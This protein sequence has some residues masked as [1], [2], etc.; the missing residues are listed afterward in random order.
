MKKRMLDSN[1]RRSHSHS[2]GEDKEDCPWQGTCLSLGIEQLWCS[3]LHEQQG[4]WVSS[5]EASGPETGG[6][7]GISLES[8]R[9]LALPR[10]C[11]MLVI[12]K[13]WSEGAWGWRRGGREIGF[14]DGCLRWTGGWGLASATRASMDKESQAAEAGVMQR[15][16]WETRRCSRA[17]NRGSGVEPRR[18]PS[19]R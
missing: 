17:Q 12:A 1:L 14:K 9:W 8:T 7:S 11:Q 15:D 3:G 10:P 6:R 19:F 18:H 4:S 5:G 16:G 13:W 2:V